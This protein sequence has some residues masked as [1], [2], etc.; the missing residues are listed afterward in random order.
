MGYGKTQQNTKPYSNQGGDRLKD[1]V[2]A[3]SKRLGRLEAGMADDKWLENLT[4]D[5]DLINGS[6]IKNAKIQKVGKFNL[7]VSENNG[8]S[9]Y[10]LT[11]QSV[12]RYIPV[13]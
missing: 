11:K 9:Q 13:G 5:I 3:I 8:K 7:I 6:T 12:L 1:K 10:I 2:E 4:T